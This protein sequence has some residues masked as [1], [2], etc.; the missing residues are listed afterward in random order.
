MIYTL[1][2]NNSIIISEELPY[3]YI[4]STHGS[5][6]TTQSIIVGAGYGAEE[7]RHKITKLIDSTYV[8]Y[9][10]LTEPNGYGL[11]ITNNTGAN[12]NIGITAII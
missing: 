11:K 10:V 5:N 12:I 2:S 1:E 9:E 4:C 8:V 6:G 7:F 3:A